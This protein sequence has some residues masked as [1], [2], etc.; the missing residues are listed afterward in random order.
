MTLSRKDAIAELWRRG[1]VRWILRDYQRDILS[2]L[3]H[4]SAIVVSGHC[5]VRIGKTYDA[6]LAAIEMGFRKKNASIKFAYPTLKQA[7]QVVVPAMRDVLETCPHDLRPVINRADMTWTFPSTGAVITLAGCD[8][9]ESCDGLR[10]DKVD[11]AVVDEAGF[12]DHLDYLI[13]SVLKPRTITTGGKILLISSSPVQPSH[14][15]RRF[16]EQAEIVGAARRYTIDVLRPY[17][18]DAIVDKYIAESGGRTSTKVRREYFCEF[19]TE[20]DKAVIPE[21]VDAEATSVR[22]PKRPSHF[23][24]YVAGDT[25]FNDLSAAIFG[26]YDFERAKICIE[27]EVVCERESSMVYADRCKETEHRQAWPPNAHVTRIADAPLQVLADMYHHNGVTFGPPAKDDAE[28]SLNALRVAIAKGQIEIHP[29]CKTLIAHLRNAIW[30]T[31]RTSYERMPGFG[32]FDLLDCLK[33][34][35]RHVNRQENPF[36]RHPEGVSAETHFLLPSSMVQPANSSIGDA[37]RW[38]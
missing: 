16:H 37:F 34:L 35:V 6:V 19:V 25:G 2:L 4:P 21:W 5:S 28:A 11:L 13:D 20:L 22:E 3:D 38:R 30:N 31:G 18:G 10:G 29:R 36:P 26:Y 23:N 7:K 12:I 15:Y 17:V 8:T 32:H 33:Y 27:D 9:E 14:P 24:A 1:N